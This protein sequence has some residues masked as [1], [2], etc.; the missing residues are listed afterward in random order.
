MNYKD[1]F[2][3]LLLIKIIIN[4]KNIMRRFFVGGNWKSNNTIA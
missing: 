1:I 4:N 3:I 2:P